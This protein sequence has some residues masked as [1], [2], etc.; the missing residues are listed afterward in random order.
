MTDYTLIAIDLAKNVFQVC[1]I[2]PN[3]KVVFNKKMRRQE[4]IEFMSQQHDI[5]SLHR[6]R[7]R[8]R[9]RYISNRTGLM[10][11]IRGLLS[12]HGIIAP[13]GHQAFCC[14]LCE[15][16]DAT[17]TGLT[18]IVKQQVRYISDEYH[19]FMNR[20]KDIDKQ[21]AEQHPICQR[22]SSLPGVGS[23]N[24]NAIYSAR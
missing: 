18:P 21:L 13:Q 10:N 11:Q 17:Y 7:I 5:Q 4:L 19:Q 12:E 8:I 23:L 14:L 6:I 16:S 1:G 15:V 24:A 3:M 22:L 20:I 2:T 9:E